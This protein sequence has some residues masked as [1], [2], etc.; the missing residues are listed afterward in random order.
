MSLLSVI[1]PDAVIAPQKRTKYRHYHAR[2][3][4][5]T[6]VRRSDACSCLQR[7][8][9]HFEIHGAI[10]ERLGQ[11]VWSV[12]HDEDILWVDACDQKACAV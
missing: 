10:V 8:A 9:D 5:F 2:G 11:S 1:F 4:P 6:F 7:L 12:N 3:T